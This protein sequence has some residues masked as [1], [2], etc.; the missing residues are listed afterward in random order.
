MTKLYG[1]TPAVIQ[2]VG[3]N[4]TEMLFWMYCPIKIG[5]QVSIPANLNQFKDIVDTATKDF[6]STFGN[7]AYEGHNIYL[8]AKTLWV[9]KNNPGNRPGWH[10]D[11]FMSDDINYIWSNTNPTLFW[12]PEELFPFTQ[13]HETSLTEM[14]VAEKD[15][16]HH[17]VYPNKT[18]LRLDETVIHRVG[19]Y[20][21]SGMR[22]FV[23]VSFSTQKYDLEG[24]SINHDLQY[25]WNPRKRAETRNV[26]AK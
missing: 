14:E 12:Q 9:S 18:I 15:K 1:N 6:I 2:E 21:T 8:T 17:V 5:T 3:L 20:D 22:S 13:D 26:P 19:T 4:P 24:N 10:S 16:E 23:K 11:G 25:D 7:T